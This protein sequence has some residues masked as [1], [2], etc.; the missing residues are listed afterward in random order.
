LASGI[1]LVVPGGTAM[2][3]LLAEFG[4]PGAAFSKYTPASIVE[5]T[6]TALA[7][8]D[9]VAQRALAAAGQWNATM[10]AQHMVSALLGLCGRA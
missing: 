3:R 6:R 2:A 4:N 1:P 9:T 7:D 5:A 10:G 8:F